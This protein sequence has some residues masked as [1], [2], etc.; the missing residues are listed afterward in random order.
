MIKG[1]AQNEFEIEL[2]IQ[3]SRLKKIK[4]RVSFM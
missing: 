2:F 3:I 4:K 1:V